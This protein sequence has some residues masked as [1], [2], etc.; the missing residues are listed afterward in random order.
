M[1]KLI[2]STLTVLL[3]TPLA[4]AAPDST[5][6][7]SPAASSGATITAADENS[8]NNSIATTFNS[9]DHIDISQTANT[10]NV[11]DGTAG[12]KFICGNAADGTDRCVKWDD[13]DDQFEAQQNSATYRAFVVTS[14]TAALTDH[15]VVVGE[16]DKSIDTISPG[17][18]THVLVSNGPSADP[19][20]QAIGG[21][22]ALTLGTANSAGT[23][24]TYI[25]TDDT[26]LAFDATVPAA[27]GAAATGSATVA[28]RR[29]HVHAFPEMNRIATTWD[30]GAGTSAEQSLDTMS[31]GLI[32]S[33]YINAIV[34]ADT[35]GGGANDI[36]VG[37]RCTDQG[38]TDRD[39]AILDLDS[40]PNSQAEVHGQP[41]YHTTISSAT[42][43]AAQAANWSAMDSQSCDEIL[44]YYSGGNA[45]TNINVTDVKV[46]W[47]G[48]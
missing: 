47:F 27:L 31:G 14:G 25:R 9:H 3:I 24:T 2:I 11:G 43:G 46:F 44:V 39:T 8:R 19:S 7:I 36:K 13:T 40:Q 21:T 5:L 45:S 42:S 34:T 22:P 10:L 1:H 12:D 23:A 28:A 32:H 48:E 6:S 4:W 20:F 41:L 29:D 16:G 35:G 37:I 26:I 30:P 15:G 18:A 33:A 17:T 38:G